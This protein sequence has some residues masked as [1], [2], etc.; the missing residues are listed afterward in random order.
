M[1]FAKFALALCCTV[2]LCVGC[3][4][5]SKAPAE[6]AIKA[7][8]DA[9]A[10]VKADAQ[11]Y[12]PAEAKAVE[13]AIASAQ[14]AADKKEY[15]AAL[16]QAKG[17]PAMVSSI[18]TAIAAKKTELAGSWAAMSAS[19]PSMLAAV[20]SRI[21]MLAKSK[22]TPEGVTKDA[23][24]QAKKDSTEASDSWKDA[25]SAATSGDFAAA[26]AKANS[27]KSRLMSVMTALKMQMPK[28]V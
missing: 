24:E 2:A 26:M 25:M 5:A 13:D 10:P 22:G 11:K 21:D 16:E 4:D 20:S 18:G 7:G 12:V 14:S 9:Y 28:G 15:T 19:L 6:A 8:S 17:L 23:V 1:K 27:V 3:G